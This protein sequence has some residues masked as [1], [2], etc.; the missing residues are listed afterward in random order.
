MPR[1]LVTPFMLHHQP[2]PYLDAL[3]SAGLEAVYPTGGRSLMDPQLLTEDLRGVDAVLAGMEPF[4]RDVLAASKLR[5]IARMGV[6]YDAIDVAA[7]TR[8]GTLITITPGTNEPSVAEQTLALILGIYRG[9]PGRDHEARSGHWKRQTLPR[10]AGKTLGLIGLGRIGRALVPRALGLGL[11]IMAC[12]PMADAAFAAAHQVR[13]CSLDE[14]LA[15]ADIV[16]L[17][18]PR[19]PETENLINA[20]ALAR[21]KSGSVLINTARGEVVD[22]MALVDALRSRHLL[23]AGLDV[24]RV[25]PL[26]ADHPLTKLDNVLLSPHMG[27]LDHESVVAMSHKAAWCIGELFQ[28]RWP[29]GCVVNH[30]LREGW[31]W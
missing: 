7:A 21:M 14:L 3:S 22:E 20:A 23:G 31:H 11:K 5:V 9:F 18:C 6:G 24:F 26:P 1:V 13:L 27:G 16:S 30:S 29:D 15:E 4:N 8:G 17:H 10:L 28:K 25:E 2:G 12:D 19:T